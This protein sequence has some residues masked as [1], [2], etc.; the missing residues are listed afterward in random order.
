VIVSVQDL[1]DDTDDDHD[2]FD[3][4]LIGII[5]MFFAGFLGAIR[6]LFEEV[7]LQDCDLPSSFLVGVDS[8]ISLIVVVVFGILIF[9]FDPLDANITAADI[10]NGLW[11][12]MSN[13]FIM[14][15]FIIFLICVF[16]KDVLQMEVVKLSSAL[17][18]K[19]IQQLYPFVTW[20]LSLITYYIN[21]KYGT[22]WHGYFTWLLLLGLFQ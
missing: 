9:T 2:S 4:H 17:T 15:C 10:D 16:G 19:M 5:L 1:F 21:H 13:A 7:L 18:R 11:F 12:A 20:I 3:Q 22:G 8:I 14:V 6:N